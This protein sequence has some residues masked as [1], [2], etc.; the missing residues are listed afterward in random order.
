MLC[1]TMPHYFNALELDWPT[2]IGE[3]RYKHG[4]SNSV[5]HGQ[6]DWILER[7]GRM[8]KSLG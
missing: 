7:Q 1:G 8:S 3:K 5:S 4:T 6:K 2:Q